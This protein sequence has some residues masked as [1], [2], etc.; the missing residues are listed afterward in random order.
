MFMKIKRETKN[1]INE[2]DFLQ[3][4]E[5]FEGSQTIVNI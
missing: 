5:H 4:D 3:Q 1:E 2:W